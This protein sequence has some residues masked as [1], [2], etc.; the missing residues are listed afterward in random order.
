MS[1][2]VDAIKLEIQSSEPRFSINGVVIWDHAYNSYDSSQQNSLNVPNPSDA[3]TPTSARVTRSAAK[4]DVNKQAI[5]QFLTNR[6][7]RGSGT[8]NKNIIKQGKYHYCYRRR[9]YRGGY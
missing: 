7:R 4:G 9:F 2:S 5:E 8:K 3:S 1:S 6:T